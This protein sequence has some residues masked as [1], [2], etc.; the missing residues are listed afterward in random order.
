[1]TRREKFGKLVL[2]EETEATGLG[3]E[4]RS[5]KLGPT[6][7]EKIVT[8]LRLIPGIS[9]NAELA[10]NLMD[11][12][13][14]AA[15]L[16]NPNILKIFGIGKV[17]QSYY[18]SY[19]HLE[20]K[21]L[22]AI[23]DRCRHESFPFQ[24]EHALLIASKV[25]S[26]LEYAHG[27]RNETGA[28]YFH[29]LL[30]PSQILVSYE[31]EVRVKG[32][33]FWPSKIRQAQALAPE[34]ARY[35]APEQSTGSGDNRSDVYALGAVLFET[36]TGEVPDGNLI[37]RLPAARLLSPASEDTSLPKP[38]ADILHRALASDPAARYGEMQEMRKAVD[39]LLFS[40]DFTPTTFNLAFFMHSLYREDI[41]RETR[42]IKEEKEASYQQFLS[43]EMRAAALPKPAPPPPPSSK[44]EPVDPRLIAAARAAA[45]AATTE[46]AAHTVAVHAPAL[47]AEAAPPPDS[48]SAPPAHP[49]NQ[50][51]PGLSARDAAASFTFHKEG[52]KGNRRPLLIG[53]AGVAVVTVV[54][55]LVLFKRPTPPPPPPAP[56]TLSPAAEAAVTRVKE[57]ED[58]L[59]ALEKDKA[60]AQ[61][62][63][64]EE[65]KKKV[66][67]QAAARGQAV[68]TAAVARAQE[69]ARRRAKEEQEQRQQEELRRLA[70]QKKAEEAHLAEERRKAEEAAHAEQA[71]QEAARAAEQQ[72]AAATPPPTTQVAEPPPIS[73][74]P[75]VR[76][77]TLVNLTDP[78]VTPP[79]V[80]KQPPL[81]Y[82]PIALRQRVQGIVE[83]NVLVDE[84]GNVTEA[85]VVQGAGGRAGLNEAAVENAKKRRYRP[86]TKEGVPVKVWLPV[87]VRFE[88]PR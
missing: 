31:G 74:P 88:L 83:L 36:L 68:D 30:T 65:A 21:S 32:F 10:R 19:E 76:A 50:S 35:L 27:R 81:I 54:G 40:G 5:A 63:A 38:L 55:L 2:L 52:T 85:Q 4:Y 41:E 24:V 86:A 78:G 62:K 34:D 26:A 84:R 51:S 56:T 44:T 66:E 69:D 16:Q 45:D 12:A 23:L 46:V 64:A 25:A 48:P 8:I 17:E 22:R 18:I 75:G 60:D 79:V 72:A 1:M 42:A 87:R 77:G 9:T 80:E 57:L 28:R 71:R 7:L 47:E 15:Q 37:A 49:P 20:G 14:V 67:A 59:A 6:G 58:K 73:P 53:L 70:E 82:P 43:E 29:G 33:G 39:T 3:A 11:Q 61:L 13:K